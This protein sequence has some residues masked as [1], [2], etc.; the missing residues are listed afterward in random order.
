MVPVFKLPYFH[1]WNRQNN[2]F[3][4]YMRKN[5]YSI[6][7]GLACGIKVVDLRFKAREIW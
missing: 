3:L 1:K 7:L 6:A 4:R 2:G 5:A